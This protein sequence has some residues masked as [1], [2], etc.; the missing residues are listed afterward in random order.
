MSHVTY[1]GS[2]VGTIYLFCYGLSLYISVIYQMIDL[3]WISLVQ[4]G[5]V[6]GCQTGPLQPA[7]FLLWENKGP[8]IHPGGPFFPINQDI[9]KA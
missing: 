2:K 7:L 8:I 3:M 6:G 1:S 4:R 5:T 9:E